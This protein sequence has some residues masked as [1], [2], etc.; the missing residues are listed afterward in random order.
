MGCGSSKTA[1]VVVTKEAEEG[2]AGEKVAPPLTEEQIQERVVAIDKP[3]DFRMKSVPLTVRYAYVSQRGYYPDELNKN[4]QDAFCIAENVCGEEETILFG[5][6]DG[7]GS[8][9][10]KCSA[11]VRDT[12]LETLEHKIREHKGDF[13]TAYK[14]TFIDINERLHANG[15]IDDTMSG[16]TSITCF[17]SGAEICI[18]NI[19]DSR[20]IIGEKRQTK[21]G[22]R[23]VAYSLSIDQTPYRAD[24]RERVKKV[25]AEVMSC[26]QKD[27]VVPYHENWGINL[28]EDV[29]TGGDPPRVWERGQDYPGCAFTRSI[30]DA[31]AE[32][33]GV[34]AEPELLSKELTR[35]DQF[36]LIAS[37]GIFEFITNQG[38]ADIVSQYEDPLE[39]ARAIVAEAYRLW[40]QYEVRTDDI[41]IIVLRLHWEPEEVA[42]ALGSSHAPLG[43][44]ASMTPEH[45]FSS[46]FSTNGSDLVSLG[47]EFGGG[48]RPVRRGLSK[49]KKSMIMSSQ[50]ALAEADDDLEDKVAPTPKTAEE[51]QRI[52]VAVKTNFLFSH[53]NDAQRQELYLAMKRVEVKP[54]DV[55]IRQGDPGDWFYVVDSGVFVVTQRQDEAGKEKEVHIFTYK[56]EGGVHH[57]FGELALMYS[58][59][60]A[61]TVTADTA[62]VLWAMARSSFRRVLMK[63]SAQTLTKV[64]RSVD[65][66]RSLSTA[67]LQRLQDILT[68]VQYADGADIISQGDTGKEFYII[69]EGAVVCTRKEDLSDESE[70]PS[71]LMRL[72]QYQYFGERAL[73]HDAPRAATV[74]A[75]GPTKCLSVERNAFEE[76]LGPLQSIIDEDAK[77]REKQAL[78]KQL[79]T[80]SVGLT[81]TSLDDFGVLAVVK[82][83]DVGDLAIVAKPAREAGGAPSYYAMRTLVKQRVV[84]LA[85]MPLIQREHELMGQLSIS[86]HG[87]AVEL[88]SIPTERAHYA[89]YKSILVTN[90]EAVMSEV[91]SEDVSRF[92]VAAIAQA[93]GAVHDASIV[94]RNVNPEYLF[95][96]TGGYVQL[97]D[98]RLAKLLDSK[99][100]TTCGAPDYLAPEVVKGEGHGVAADWWAL[101]VLLYEMLVGESPFKG[102]GEMDM[103]MNITGHRFKAELRGAAELGRHTLALI[104]ELLHPNPN[105]RM[106]A[107]RGLEDLQAHMFF[108]DFDWVALAS[109]HTK[110]PHLAVVGKLFEQVRR[111][112]PTS[113]GEALPYPEY[114]ARG[115]DVFRDFGV[116]RMV[117]VHTMG[118]ARRP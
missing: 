67:Q 101:G 20:A 4:N 105:R 113:V 32:D 58:K 14:Q 11:F 107:K 102:K 2:G 35:D 91:M 97:L 8:T 112:T 39:G 19:G 71:E 44:K 114:S 63:S 38:A 73:L 7:H 94:Y 10:D 26:D 29:D 48:N 9:G 100:F 66:L 109:R 65:I 83:G 117:R 49:E 78:V 115:E 51:I 62:G 46:R 27:N 92:Y 96:D 56:N 98:F 17:M 104:D 52:S 24:E 88:V 54:G 3:R 99:T 40:L 42:G 12:V 106:G 28:G 30:G 21:S 45:K 75:V 47:L 111:K 81:A 79:E 37:D 23:L 82:H 76:V 18:A 118:L 103:Y 60:R 89:I 57:C 108:S 34:F 1:Q 110:A 25:G 93:L 64:L 33:I 31:I 43:R 72:K 77:V 80:E 53:L 6:F 84:E 116:N 95:L 36:I 74:T 15:E 68:E 13:E 90:L 55:V 86:T 41:T 22:E 5:V 61:A 87:V 69:V 16:T 70:V 85:Q 50:A 59:P